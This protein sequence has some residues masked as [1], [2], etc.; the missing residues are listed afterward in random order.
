MA[1]ERA[2]QFTRQ[3]IEYLRAD[4]FPQSADFARQ[5][6]E[7]DPLNGEAYGVLGIALAQM[8]RNAE[9]TEALRRSAELC[10]NDAKARYNL[11]A[12]LYRIGDK[13]E[14][15]REL[16]AALELQPSHR[17]AL[18]LHQQLQ[19]ELGSDH[20]RT[21]VTPPPV[22]M[23]ANAPPQQAPG[24]A[25]MY[26]DPNRAPRPTHSLPFIERLGTGWDATLWILWSLNAVVTV[27]FYVWLFSWVPATESLGTAPPT[28]QMATFEE[29]FTQGLGWSM[30]AGLLALAMMAVWILDLIDRRPS[31]TAMTLG[32]VGTL[33]VPCCMCYLNLLSILLF[34]GY[35]V[36]TRR[37]TS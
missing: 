30:A 19:R 26:Y 5:A 31:P 7:L 6:I 16:R 37:Y 9:A 36:A 12:H 33:F 22:N 23:E 20:E 8:G 2:D 27:A 3:A 29:L 15:L 1:D 34:V 13:Q 21:T 11:A 17:A 14:A 24:Q 4:R 25:P 18:K 28:Q 10:P 35:F 32:V